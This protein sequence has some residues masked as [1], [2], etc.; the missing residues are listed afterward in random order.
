[1]FANN[2]L[3]C[4]HVHK[5]KARQSCSWLIYSFQATILICARLK[6]IQISYL[7]VLLGEFVFFFF[8]FIEQDKTM[9]DDETK[10]VI[11]IIKRRRAE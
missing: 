9:L 3:W 1:M 10:R 4:I 5:R 11:R 6:K 8:F 7:E 2:N